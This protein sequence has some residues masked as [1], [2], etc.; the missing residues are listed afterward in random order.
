MQSALASDS[1]GG[2]V[3]GLEEA[4]LDAVDG[5]AAE[6]AVNMMGLE[7]LLGRIDERLGE[8]N[9]RVLLAID[10]YEMIDRKIGE[11]LFSEDVLAAIRDSIQSHRR[12]TWAFVGIHQ[13]DEL[14]HAPWDSYLVSARTIDVEPFSPEETRLLLTQPMEHSSLW[15]EGS[16]RPEFEPGFWGD[17]GIERI[18]SETGGWPHLV[19]L[20]A[21]TTI[22]LLNDSSRTAVDGPLLERALSKACRFGDVV[23]GRLVEGESSLSGEWEYLQAFAERELQAPPD[24]EAV[25]RSLRR[26]LLIA[27]E[28]AHWRM[29]TP[30]FSRWLRERR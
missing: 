17:G 14:S 8:S 7:R 24:D 26:R 2:F 27:E 9:R 16:K 28:G 12:L 6:D 3:A 15:S 18:H 5:V 11:G 25:R 19:Q 4:L 20:V 10:E 30:L 1:L 22:N 13:A 21:E 23:L 29:R